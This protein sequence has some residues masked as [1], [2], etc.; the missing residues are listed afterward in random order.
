MKKEVDI[1]NKMNNS[2]NITGIINNTFRPQVTFKKTR[3]KL[4]TTP[5]LSTL[6]Y[7]S[8][9]WTTVAQ[10]RRITAAEI[11]YVRKTAGYILD[12]LQNTEIA[13]ALNITPVLDKIQA[14]RKNW[15]QLTKR[16]LQRLPGI[17]KPQTKQQKKP[18]QTIKILDVSDRKASTSGPMPC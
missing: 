12:R 7:S 13:K 14:Y 18:G 17:T 10:A 4:D 16:M 11:K 8:E 5:A 3:I 15:L 2:L 1:D 6:L 9:N